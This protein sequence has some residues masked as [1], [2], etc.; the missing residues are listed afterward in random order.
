MLFWSLIFGRPYELCTLCSV[1]FVLQAASDG[2]TVDLAIS[3]RRVIKMVGD[4]GA[5]IG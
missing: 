3:R 4:A 5:P 1:T 2:L